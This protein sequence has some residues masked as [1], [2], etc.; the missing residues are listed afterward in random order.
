[1]EYPH[2]K[3]IKYLITKKF[4]SLEIQE[5]C[6]RLSLLV[7]LE[8]D[9]IK[10]ESKLGA[11][12]SS[13][14]PV[15]NRKNEYF[16]KWLRKKGVIQIWKNGDDIKRATNF[17]Y[18][19]LVRKDFETLL[20]ATGDIAESREQLLLKHSESHVPELTI[21]ETFYD[22]FWNVGSLTREGLFEFL[23]RNT[24][25][26]AKIAALNGNLVE[27]YARA[28]L[29]HKIS[30]EQFYNNL[31]SLA[32]HQI[33]LARMSGQVLNGSSLMGIAAISRQA[34]DAL[35]SRDEMIGENTVDVLD[36]I[37][38]QASTFK[39]KKIHAEEVITIEQ[40]EELD[41]QPK[42]QIVRD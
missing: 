39:I 11:F 10:M 1:M 14:E 34:L 17:L 30:S 2:A 16:C 29:T 40:L 37:R 28:G 22:I 41:E 3:Y 27:A 9:I 20:L 13:W 18:R 24:D 23:E 25:K 32:N 8:E 35:K 5:E 38:E 6:L 26:E 31:V 7:P 42:L 36:T 19:S 21:L 4:S 15:Y 33:Q 12:P